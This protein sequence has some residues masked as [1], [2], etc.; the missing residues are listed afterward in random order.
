MET[1]IVYNASYG[2]FGL[3]KQ[4]ISV[5]KERSPEFDEFKPERHNPI[6]VEVVEE[7][8]SEVNDTF[9][10]LKITQIKGNKYQIENYD[11]KE[12]VLTPQ[13]MEW[14]IIDTPEY[15]KKFPEDY[16]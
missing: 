4:A 9:S 6:L 8:K 1:K 15:R 7:L 3:S 11:G 14:H 2:G 5:L 16:L 10:D 13:A 12:Y